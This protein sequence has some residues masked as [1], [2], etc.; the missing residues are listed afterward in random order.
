MS[1]QAMET[2]SSDKKGRWNYVQVYSKERPTR[3]PHFSPENGVSMFLWN[4]GV[5]QNIAWCKTPEA[6]HLHTTPRP[7]EISYDSTTKMTSIYKAWMFYM[8]LLWIRIKFP[9]VW[10]PQRNTI[11]NYISQNIK[12]GFIVHNNLFQDNSLVKPSE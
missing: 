1:D 8:N 11:Q 9:G 3:T 2:E 6:T 10:F 4:V 5:Q 7:T 12:I